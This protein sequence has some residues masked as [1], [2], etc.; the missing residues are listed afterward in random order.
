MK[1]LFK[2]VGPLIIMS[3]SLFCLFDTSSNPNSMFELSYTALLLGLFLVSIDRIFPELKLSLQPVACA[4][5]ALFFLPPNPIA[6]SPV[7]TELGVSIWPVYT[8]TIAIAIIA[9]FEQFDEYTMHW[10]HDTEQ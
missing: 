3:S 10:D 5:L 6:N 2:I 1:Y 7:L 8:A 4:A 9:L